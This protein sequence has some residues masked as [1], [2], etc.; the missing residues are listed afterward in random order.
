MIRIMA[1]VPRME[2]V[3]ERAITSVFLSL[4]ALDD[5]EVGDGEDDA[6]VVG[7]KE[8]VVVTAVSDATSE[9]LVAVLVVEWLVVDVSVREA[10]L[11]VVMIVAEVENVD[12]PVVEE[13][14]PC[15]EEL[16]GVMRCIGGIIG[17][18]GGNVIKPVKS[19]ISRRLSSLPF[20]TPFT[21]GDAGVRGSSL[22]GGWI[23]VPWTANEKPRMKNKT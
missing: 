5:D 9:L 6:I 13:L 18:N 16:G 14:E 17:S 23:G 1:I 22:A 2:K 21:N 10:E 19:S 20:T 11:A 15:V 3:T 4:A 8:G 12:I 7:A